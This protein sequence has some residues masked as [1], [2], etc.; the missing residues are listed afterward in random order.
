MCSKDGKKDNDADVCDEKC[1]CKLY[2]TEAVWGCNV[3]K[4]NN[5]I[6]DVLGGDW[7]GDVT[8][9]AVWEPIKYGYI[10]KHMGT[11]GA[12]GGF[13]N[14]QTTTYGGGAKLAKTSDAITPEH[15]HGFTGYTFT[16]WCRAKN[17]LTTVGNKEIRECM[18]GDTNSYAADGTVSVDNLLTEE[19]LNGGKDL[20]T[21]E[22]SSE[23]I[24]IGPI[25]EPIDYTIHYDFGVGTCSDSDCPTTYNIESETITISALSKDGYEFK[26]WCSYDK[27]DNDG[28]NCS[29]ENEPSQ[30]VEISTGSTGDRWL[31]AV[32]KPITYYIC[33]KD[34]EAVK[35][36]EA[37]TCSETAAETCGDYKKSSYSDY[38]YTYTIEDTF[39]LQGGA[40][41]AK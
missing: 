5:A 28:A 10:Y 17:S 27:A 20:N 1:G 40:V 16:H 39:T 36:E 33:Y 4:N 23:L 19:E 35:N 41:P 30:T 31:Y 6:T 34:G 12:A 26:G 32:W 25:W 7:T 22:G 13:N 21:T 37:C 3:D 11:V 8:L 24:Y 2:D 38:E 29:G 9:T 15:W 18:D 14:T